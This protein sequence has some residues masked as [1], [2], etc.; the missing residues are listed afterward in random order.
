MFWQG[1]PLTTSSLDFGEDPGSAFP[2]QGH[3]YRGSVHV[4]MLLS[5]SLLGPPGSICLVDL[6]QANPSTMV[7]TECH[8]SALPSLRLHLS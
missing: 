7:S 5:L 8:S 4:K 3:S 6:C 2:L 1:K